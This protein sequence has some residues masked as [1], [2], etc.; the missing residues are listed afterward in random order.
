MNEIA[1]LLAAWS[2][3]AGLAAWSAA[4]PTRALGDPRRTRAQAL[5]VIA[6]LLAG[7]LACAIAAAGLT[8]GCALVA[9]AWMLLG[10]PYGMALNAWPA[11]T[12]AWARC[13]GCAALAGAVLLAAMAWI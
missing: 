4:V 9:G 11:G 8:G 10:W 13:S 5:T 2:T 12:L 6:L 1:A 3:F 7:Q